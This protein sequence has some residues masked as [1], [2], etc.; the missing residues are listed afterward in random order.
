MQ[1][2]GQDDY[3]D[4]KGLMCFVAEE[5]AANECADEAARNRE[6]MQHSFR[7]APTVYH[8]LLFVIS[9]K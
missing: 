5:E 1:Q 4:E 7:Y 6:Q 3:D 8:A 2:G 9:I